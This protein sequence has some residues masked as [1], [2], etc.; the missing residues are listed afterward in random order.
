[1]TGHGTRRLGRRRVSPPPGSCT[2]AL[3]AVSIR[4]ECH[5]PTAGSGGGHDRAGTDGSDPGPGHGGGRRS[6]R[7]LA[8][9]TQAA[10][11]ALAASEAAAG[12]E[13]VAGDEAL[14]ADELLVEEVSID[15]M[16]GVY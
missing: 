3:G 9:E 8:G 2:L 1:M 11:E 6:D 14:I 16:C 5:Y 4:T 15:G 10:G 13:A 12:D 7:A